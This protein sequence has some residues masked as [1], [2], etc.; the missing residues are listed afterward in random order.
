MP[1]FLRSRSSVQTQGLG[2]AFHFKSS[3]PA[4]QDASGLSISIGAKICTAV[5]LLIGS[6][7]QRPAPAASDVAMALQNL[8]ELATV[9]YTVTKVVA[10]ND[11]VDWYKLGER[12][13]LI[14]CQA[15]IK[16]GINLKEIDAAQVVIN[17]RSISLRLP[18]PKILSVNLPPENIKVAWQQVG[19]LRGSFTATETNA[20]MVQAEQQMWNAG[21]IVGIDE[22]AKV[23]TQSAVGQLLRQLGFTQINITFDAPQVQR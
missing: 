2:P 15:T 22:Q 23:N 21:N 5:L 7:C 14:T 8:S 20:L 10:A 11:D 12:K 9:E 16:A 3:A 4:P 13:V 18:P 17:E 1:N 19:F 6:A